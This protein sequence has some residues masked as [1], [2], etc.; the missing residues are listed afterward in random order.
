[1]VW[2][3]ALP[4]MRDYEEGLAKAIQTLGSQTLAAASPIGNVLDLKGQWNMLRN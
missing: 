3:D 2:K 1:M 4:Q